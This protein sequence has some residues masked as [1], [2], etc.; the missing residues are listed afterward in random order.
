MSDK[1]AGVVSILVWFYKIVSAL[2]FALF[3]YQFHFPVGK[4]YNPSYYIVLHLSLMRDLA[5]LSQADLL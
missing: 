5:E 2:V 3:R 1:S 4:Y